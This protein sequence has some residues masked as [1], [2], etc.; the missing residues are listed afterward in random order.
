M[1]DRPRRKIPCINYAV[2]G[3]TGQKAL[4][5]S[6]P[7]ETHQVD[8]QLTPKESKPIPQDFTQL[9][10]D[11][12]VTIEDIDD[13]IDENPTFDDVT[14]CKLEHHRTNLRQ[15]QNSLNKIR[16]QSELLSE[17]KVTLDV[18]IKSY[19]KSNKSTNN[20]TKILQDK[21]KQDEI[22]RKQK[23]MEFLVNNINR[24]LKELTEELSK[25]PDSASD[26]EISKWKKDI[27][28][29][30]SKI[31]KLADNIK[32]LMQSCTSDSS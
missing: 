1:S 7:D 2:Y 4:K 9:E 29:F 11:I 6:Q 19:I 28:H 24:D 5:M 20:N 18:K 22:Q 13:L 21:I 31:D 32:T 16:P 30:S 26:E 12:S 25:D 27:P 3:S 8:E 15:L 10:S 14:T 17:I 23:S